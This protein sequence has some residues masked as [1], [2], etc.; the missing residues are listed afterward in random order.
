[1]KTKLLLFLVSVFG[2]L[3]PAPCQNQR[4]VDS[5]TRLLTT[6]VAGDRYE[7]LYEL[8]FEYLDRDNRHA[9]QIIEEAETAQSVNT[10]EGLVTGPKERLA[11]HLRILFARS[12]TP[13]GKSRMI[14]TFCKLDT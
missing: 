9:F 14:F 2:A 12:N 4:V 6:K 3:Q 11:I 13:G 7:P 10:T 1:M 8:A 5:L